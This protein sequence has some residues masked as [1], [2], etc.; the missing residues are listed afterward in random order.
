M[1]RPSSNLEAQSL[2]PADIFLFRLP[3]AVSSRL[4]RMEIAVAFRASNWASTRCGPDRPDLRVGSRCL[5][6]NASIQQRHSIYPVMLANGKVNLLS[7]RRTVIRACMQPS[8]SGNPTAPVAPLKLES[9]IGQFLSEMLVTHPHLVPD[10]VEQQLE[11][12]QIDRDADKEK[13]KPSASGSDLVLYRRIAE[14]KANERDKALEEILYALVVQKFMDADVPLVP[15]IA[16]SSPS[17]SGCV[18][19]WPAMEDQKLER[20]H[21]PEAY[22]MIQN[23]LALILGKRLGHSSSIAQISK[24]RAG[25]VYAASVIYGYFLKRVDQ[26]F[27]LEKTMKFLPEGTDGE[28]TLTE[29]MAD[30]RIPAEVSPDNPLKHPEVSSWSDGVDNG[31]YVELK[32]C[33]LRTYVMSF[34]GET[35]QRYANIRSKE[36]VNI[37]EKHTEALFGRPEMIFTPDGNI[38]SSKDVKIMISFG[39]LRRVFLE[40]V[41]FGSIL[42]DVESYVDSRYHFVTH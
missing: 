27:Q 9:P 17:I 22:E 41:T 25:Q 4:S 33:R 18:D 2:N 21:S 35:L 20:L 10:A 37:I 7:R 31:S 11:K 14:V 8:D 29:V 30:E 1:S 42:W 5:P 13:E 34:D 23:H 3:A 40:A 16:Q 19:T 39:G 28:V 12:L 26:R 36:A 24:R 15:T 38:D 32:P 6:F